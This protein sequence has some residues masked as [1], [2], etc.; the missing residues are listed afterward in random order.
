[1]SICNVQKKYEMLVEKNKKLEEEMAEL[2][3]TLKGV[4]VHIYS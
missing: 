2:V 4:K 1:M 3:D